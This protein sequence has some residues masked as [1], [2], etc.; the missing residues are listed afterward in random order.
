MAFSSPSISSESMLPML[1]TESLFR[2]EQRMVARLH[3]DSYFSSEF[4][5]DNRFLNEFS[6]LRLF[7]LNEICET[8][9]FR[10]LGARSGP[11]RWLDAKECSDDSAC[12]RLRRDDLE[13]DAI[14]SLLA[15]FDIRRLLVRRWRARIRC[16]V[17]TFVPFLWRQGSVPD[18]F[19]ISGPRSD[20][21]S[22]PLALFVSSLLSFFAVLMPL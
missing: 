3:T 21:V 9:F 13:R 20:V 8:R 16:T 6:R 22:A 14:R 11:P 19:G 5:S 1:V 10:M 12:K 7:M 15:S 17:L 18:K 4:L 2:S